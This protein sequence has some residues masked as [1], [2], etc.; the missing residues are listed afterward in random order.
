MRYQD[1]ETVMRDP[2]LTLEVVVDP[3]SV[4]ASAFTE[5]WSSI[6][7]CGPGCRAGLW[8]LVYL[9]MDRHVGT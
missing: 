8:E 4:M 6:V 7:D 9:R 5:S 3:G 1:G 2:W